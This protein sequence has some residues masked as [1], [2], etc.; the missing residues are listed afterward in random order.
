MT[1]KGMKVVVVGGG[2]MGSMI[3]WRLSTRGYDVVCLE[4]DG[5]AHSRSAVAGDT[6]LFRRSY[7]GTTELNDVLSIAEAQWKTLNTASGEDVFV[8]CG[9]LYIGDSAGKY[10]AELESCCQRNDL[11]YELLSASQI[12]KRFPQHRVS[13]N[14]SGLYEVSAGFLRTERAVH[15]AISQAKDFGSQIVT[16]APV[17]SI[18]DTGD[19]VHIS[20]QGGTISADAVVIA[21]GTGSPA[22]L[23]PDIRKSLGPRREILTWFPTKDPAEY[24]P[25]KFPIFVH[26]DGGY[27]AY[28][29]PSLDG[30]VL[31]C[32]LDNRARP[33]DDY[34]D[35]RYT[36]T[37]G[38]I[39]E[40]ETTAD[41]FFNNI[42][43]EVSRQE[44]LADLY[45]TDR[46]A[47]VGRLPTY[48]RTY[49]ATGF[50]GAGFKMSAG[51]GE[52]LAQ[53]IS[54]ESDDLPTF[55]DPARFF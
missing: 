49:V 37:P 54:G 40:S 31:K 52:L 39:T 6:R 41:R 25:E 21:A 38:E 29:A 14:E 13:E 27:S 33:I 46:Q 3:T 36:L 12:R 18:Q 8:N 35:H 7:R 53:S 24:E 44:C 42:E 4:S 11:Q 23:P 50:S 45:T 19:C 48:P 1:E 16:K 30:S 20:Y 28:G 9:G 43:P 55:W 26:I 22:L 34:P 5:V 10:L 15:A 47:I 51:V 32:T 2:T 17:R